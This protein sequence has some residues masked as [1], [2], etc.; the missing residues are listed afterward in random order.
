MENKLTLISVDKKDGMAPQVGCYKW[1]TS[2]RS[3]W[4]CSRYITHWMP[5]P[6]PPE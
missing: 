3:R 1:E 6:D 5:L 2:W 4:K